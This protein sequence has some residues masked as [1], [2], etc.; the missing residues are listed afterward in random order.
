VI[1][2]GEAHVDIHT[3]FLRHARCDWGDLGLED[4][5]M[6]DDALHTEGRLLS[7]YDVSGLSF[8]IVTEWDRSV[9]TLMLTHEY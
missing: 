4:K 1:A 8:Y 7:R 3:L 9:T 5:A 6:N 2:A